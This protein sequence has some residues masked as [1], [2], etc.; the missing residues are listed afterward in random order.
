[1]SAVVDVADTLPAGFIA[2]R[3]VSMPTGK[4]VVRVRQSH[5]DLDQLIGFAA[6]NNAKRGFLF[7]SKVLGKHW[8]VRPSVMSAMHDLLAGQIPPNAGTVVFIGMAETAIGLGQG[9]FESWCQRHPERRALY[10]PT[11]R[12]RVGTG[13]VMVFQET[14]S[15]A[16]HQYLHV[17]A[18]PLR[19]LL[20]D[21]TSLVLI[22]DEVSTGNTF[23]NLV[24]TLRAQCPDLASVHISTIT[25]FMGEAASVALADRFGLPVTHAGALDGEYDFLPDALPVAQ[26]L[27]HSDE[28]VANATLTGHFGR[29]GIARKLPAPVALAR[30]LFAQYRTGETVLVLGTG[31]FL[32]PPF[33]LARE[34][35]QLGAD[36]TF[37]S[38]TRSP[39]LQWGA[40]M[41]VLQFADIYGEGVDNFLY[42][43]QPQ[44]YDHVLICHE[45]ASGQGLTQL[46]EALDARLL[47]FNHE[48][49]C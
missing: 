2:E 27:T 20:Q 14:H 17:P 32:H 47:H 42:N 23:V 49:G 22:D 35:E 41:H 15:H 5:L 33:L 34:L 16:P 3:R 9:I 4:M 39:I 12:Y 38:T 46:A 36:V 1:M 11:T 48:G 30:E 21:A 28:G 19:S 6:R 40:A 25:N 8:P 31:E 45:T 7:L 29:V 18:E 26:T 24:S 37:Q 13:D 10:L 44:Q 43:V